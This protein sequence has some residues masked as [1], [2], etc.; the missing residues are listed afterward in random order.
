[1]AVPAA[2]VLVLEFLIATAVEVVA[3][4]VEVPKPVLA[5]VAV[6]QVTLGTA[7]MAVDGTLLQVAVS[8][9]VALLAVAAGHLVL[10]LDRLAL[11]AVVLEFWAEA[12]RGL[13]APMATIQLV[14]VVA[15][16]GLL[17]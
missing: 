12:L 17:G 7:E 6:P 8:V 3:D 1:M 2:V 15:R 10:V 11:A 9:A 13:L 16:A 14:A 5:A 4:Q